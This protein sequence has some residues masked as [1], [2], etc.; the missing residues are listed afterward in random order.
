MKKEC[1][2]C[3]YF[4]NILIS[5]DQL[6]NTIFGGDPDETI[7]SRAGKDKLKGY[8][9]AICLCWFLNKLDPKHCSKSIEEDEGDDKV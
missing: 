3:K 6:I 7:S 9:W 5:I 8:K 1:K 2:I 4:W